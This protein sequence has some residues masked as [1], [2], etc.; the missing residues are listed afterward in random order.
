MLSQF[1][2]SLQAKT[3]VMVEQNQSYIKWIPKTHVLFVSPYYILK[4]FLT[5]VQVLKSITKIWFKHSGIFN[6][7]KRQHETLRKTFRKQLEKYFNATTTV[8]YV[9][10][11]RHQN[12]S[13]T[14][15]MHTDAPFKCLT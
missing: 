3:D 15:R 5:S 12:T 1:L 14:A 4:R 9:L 10:I 8:S 6:K 11:K 13:F 2:L 7:T